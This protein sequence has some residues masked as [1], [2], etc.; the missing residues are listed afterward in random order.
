[1]LKEVIAASPT[2]GA[3]KDHSPPLDYSPTGNY[4]SSNGQDPSN[5]SNRS[6]AMPVRLRQEIEAMH[7][8]KPANCNGGHCRGPSLNCSTTLSPFNEYSTTNAALLLEV[9]A[10]TF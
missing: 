1:M 10:G 3:Q 6:V 8:Q 9:A 5:P 4:S 7:I 2:S